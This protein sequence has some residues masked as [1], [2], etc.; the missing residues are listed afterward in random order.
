[1]VL[2]HALMGNCFTSVVGTIS[3]SRIAYEDS[4][5]TLRF[6]E[7]AKQVRIRPALP[8][9]KREDVVHELRD[10][11]H[12]L[13][14][15]LLKARSGRTVIDRQLDKNQ[16]LEFL[17]HELLRRLRDEAGA[18]GFAAYDEGRMASQQQVPTPGSL[19]A[20]HLP[21]DHV[22]SGNDSPFV[23]S[24]CPLEAGTGGPPVSTED[25]SPRLRHGSARLPRF[26]PLNLSLVSEDS[27]AVDLSGTG[28]SSPSS[29]ARGSRPSSPDP[30]QTESAVGSL[31]FVN[32]VLR[33]GAT[34]G[35]MEA[36]LGRSSWT[37]T[38]SA[39][40]SLPGGAGGSL[41][42][43]LVREVEYW[44][45][46]T[47][48]R[49]VPGAAK[50]ANLTSTLRHLRSQLLQLQTEG[51]TPGQADA[52]AVAATA[53]AAAA[54]AVA[55][56]SAGASLALSGSFPS[57]QGNSAPSG[58]PQKPY[59]PRGGQLAPQ[60]FPGTL[61]SG[62]RHAVGAGT[63]TPLTSLPNGRMVGPSMPLP[64]WS[65]EAL[66]QRASP[67]AHSPP[68]RHVSG[69]QMGL[70][71]PVLSL[72]AT[73]ALPF[74]VSAPPHPSSPTG[75]V[76]VATPCPP[77]RGAVSPAP[78]TWIFWPAQQCSRDVVSP[79]SQ[80]NMRHPG[81]SPRH[82]SEISQPPHAWKARFVMA[83]TTL[84]PPSSPTAKSASMATTFSGTT[85][86]ANCFVS[87]QHRPTLRPYAEIGP[88]SGFV[89]QPFT[90]VSMSLPAAFEVPRAS[91]PSW[92]SPRVPIPALLLPR[93]VSP[94][95]SPLSL[96]RATPQLQASVLQAAPGISVMP[97]VPV[98][99]LPRSLSPR[100]SPLGSPRELLT[101]LQAPSQGSSACTAAVE[102]SSARGLGTVPFVWRDACEERGPASRPR[103]REMPAL[104]SPT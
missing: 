13:Q 51:S 101:K 10:E 24:W 16:A 96:P 98:V 94:P 102:A 2:G 61:S 28:A 100:L 79:L 35:A 8:V 9:L 36:S 60:C 52:T 80:R 69:G 93:P 76:S 47:G 57:N 58:M 92:A 63:A 86:F 73:P 27:G 49:S 6:C 22:M 74:R 34:A 46:C 33:N 89:S 70:A 19:P 85:S 71:R 17:S 77:M 1:M 37:S 83:A 14:V 21:V 44:L 78:R 95:P 64:G 7:S 53:A 30:D 15:E 104:W 56:A 12:R 66:L 81:G 59:T 48:Q 75:A 82:S 99:V 87:T 42:D 72:A 31:D 62:V 39:S 45:N 20:H 23:A 32:S 65:P 68:R 90:T 3:P 29:S 67:S 18:L 88:R 54:V 50:L 4:L 97:D 103:T 40:G 55:A 41:E 43:D 38:G 91:V 26:L 84:S 11:V 25:P 5:A